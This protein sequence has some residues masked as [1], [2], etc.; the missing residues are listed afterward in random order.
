MAPTA[1]ETDVAL[2]ALAGALV[3]ALAAGA[4]EVPGAAVGAPLKQQF[5]VGLKSW[6]VNC[7]LLGGMVPQVV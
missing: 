3:G 4:P 1:T 7:L 5:S 6:Y 2:E